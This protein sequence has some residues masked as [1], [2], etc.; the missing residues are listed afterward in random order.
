VNLR[1][2]P[3]LPP[4][5]NSFAGIENQPRDQAKGFDFPPRGHL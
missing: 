2:K 3:V 4:Q 5:Y 1:T